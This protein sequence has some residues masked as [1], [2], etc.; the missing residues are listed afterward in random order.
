MAM[1]TLLLAATAAATVDAAPHQRSG[2]ATI[3]LYLL[4][5]TH[6]DVGWLETPENLARVN[7]IAAYEQRKMRYV[8]QTTGPDVLSRY[9]KRAG[10][11]RY[12][13][14]IS[15][16]TFVDAKQARRNVFAEDAKVLVMHHLSWRPQLRQPERPASP[17]E[18][19]E[20]L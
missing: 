3:E 9:I 12:V 8:F 16:R 4:P 20:E 17:E 11:S 18:G 1:L 13:C 15:N 19:E 7:G 14:S 6:A 10:L 2:N 5:H